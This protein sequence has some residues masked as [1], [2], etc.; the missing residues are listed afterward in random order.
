MKKKIL[1]ALLAL[2]MLL[3]LGAP[4]LAAEEDAPRVRRLGSE[5]DFVRFLGNCARE[6]YS[7]STRFVLTRDLDLTGL[8]VSAAPYFAGELDGGGHTVRGLALDAVGSRQGLFRQVG[9]TGVIRALRVEGSVLP[10]GTRQAVGGLVGRNEGTLEDCAFS[11]EVRGTADVGG[12]VGENTGTIRGCAFIGTVC[13]EH[14]VGGLVG[15]NTGLVEQSETDA[16]VNN[17]EIIPQ[18]ERRFDLSSLSGDDLVD[19]SDLGGIAGENTGVLHACSAAGAVGFSLTGY[20]VGGVAGKS[21]GYI[22]ACS[23]AAAVEGRRDV[24][25]IVGQGVPY[26]V[27]ELTDSKLQELSRAI[28]GLNGLLSAATKKLDDRTGETA[29]VLRGMSQDSQRAMNAAGE[30]LRAGRNQTSDYLAGITVDAD[31]GEI[32]LPNPNFAAADTSALT[33]ALAG[34]FT[35]S[36]LLTETLDGTVGEAAEDVKKI[37]GQISY[38]FNVI[39][40][41]ISDVGS[42]D[43]L[44]RRDLSY[45]EVYDHN[46][47]AVES[48]VNTGSVRAETC[49]GGIVGTLAFELSFDMEDS[50]GTSGALPT[51]AEQLLFAA[52]R[53]C[54]SRGSVRARGDR[55]G[56]VAGRVDVGAVVDCVFRGTAESQTGD[57]VGGIVGESRGTVARCWSRSCLSGGKYVG[58]VAGLGTDLLDCRALTQ[59]ARYTEYAGDTAGWAEGAVSGNLYVPAGPEGVDGVS[60]IAQAESVS[61]RALL[62]EEDAPADF[63]T[64]T[65]RYLGPEDTVVETRA[66]PFGSAPGDPP[67]LA[68]QDGAAWVWDE[69]AQAVRYDDGDVGGAYLKR[70]SVL[71]SG[72]EPPLFLVEGDFFETSVLSV[73][74]FALSPVDVAC[75]GGWTLEVAGYEAPL[76]VHL[77]TEDA[78]AV[79]LSAA[80]GWQR[81]EGERDGR[82]LVF[83]IPNGGSFAVEEAA[84]AASPYPLLLLGG[85]ALLLLAL[86]LRAVGARRKS[87]KAVA[88][89]A[90]AASESAALT[91][92]PA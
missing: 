43:L 18:S 87:A 62:A 44:S 92:P 90:A 17:E 30:L 47:G 5:R 24:G 91:D 21:S 14:R 81:L 19:L 25:G 51:R 31:T 68:S 71:S 29:E 63:S 22:S 79:W 70:I 55:A 86:A 2:V 74:A 13:G 83:T 52:I 64:L 40:S 26:A 82:Y 20:N 23:N 56:G 54:D 27:W 3:S 32:R 15:R 12:L 72:E 69:T 45:E 66:V 8:A 7:A 1:S 88:A 16:R 76:R 67:E 4:A 6:S 35:R 34:L 10:T 38:I 57:Y 33:A 58:G 50:L 49:A 53:R 59:L 65:L 77:Y 75:T 80:D 85:G 41:L 39:F 37:S 78:G 60:R 11:G 42:G 48:C 46:E 28:A 9:P 36:R 73:S 61:L 84:H 89:E